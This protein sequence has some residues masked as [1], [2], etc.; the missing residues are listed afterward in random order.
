[1]GGG[2]GGLR[3]TEELRTNCLV[4]EGSERAHETGSLLVVVSAT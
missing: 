2:V 1:M 4:Q 3:I